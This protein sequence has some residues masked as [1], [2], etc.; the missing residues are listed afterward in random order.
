MAAEM[1]D[2]KGCGKPA[3]HAVIVDMAT[4]KYFYC[5][6][7]KAQFAVNAENLPI[8]NRRSLLERVRFMPL[9]AHSAAQ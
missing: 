4:R 2:G 3:S 6:A 8:E 9:E 1:C 7:C 5:D